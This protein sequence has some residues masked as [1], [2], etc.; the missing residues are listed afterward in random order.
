[1]RLIIRN[2]IRI[3]QRFKLAMTL[4]I[5]GLSIAFTA[6]MIIMMQW[7]Y[8]ITF[9]AETPNADCIYRVDGKNVFGLE[10]MP[11]CSQPMADVFTQSSPHIQ[12]GGL[13]LPWPFPSY[14][15]IDTHRGEKYTFKEEITLCTPT[16][17]DVFQFDMIE[18]SAD[19]LNAFEQILI[20]QSLAKKLFGNESAIGKRLETN[21]NQIFGS[22]GIYQVGGVFKDFPENSVIEN[23][24]FISMGDYGKDDWGTSNGSLYVRL[25]APSS[26]G[27]LLDNFYRYAEQI[28]LEGRMQESMD[29]GVYEMELVPLRELHFL[30]NSTFDFVPKADRFTLYLLF[31][32]AWVILI[33]AAINFTNFNTALSPVRMKSINTQ[34]ILGSTVGELR[35]NLTIETVLVSFGAYLLSIYLLYI[36]EYCNID[37]LITAEISIEHHLGLIALTGA[38]SVLLGLVAGLYPAYYMT[39]FQPALVLKG[40][41]GLSLSG[42]RL[43]TVLMSIQYATAFALIIAALFMSLQN[44]YIQ[45]FSLGY[46]KE[47]ILVAE[48]GPNAQQT[49]QAVRSEVLGISGVQSLTFSFD[50]ISARD[51]YSSWGR[52]FKDKTIRYYNLWCDYSFPE[53]MNIPLVEGRYFLPSDTSQNGS[54]IINKLMADMYGIT[55]GDK[56]SGM[57]VVGV[58]QDIK[59]MTLRQ[60]IEPMAFT[61]GNYDFYG[62]QYLYVRTAPKTDFFALRTELQKILDGFDNNLDTNIRFFD[63]VLESAYQSEWNLTTLITLFSFLAVF[64]SIVG[65]FGMVVFDSAYKRKEI[66][67][68]KVMG[69]TTAQILLLFNKNY[70]KMLTLCFVIAA[71]CAGYGIKVWLQNFAYKIPIYWWVFPLSFIAIAIVTVA[72]VTYQ[73]WHAANENPVNSIR[74]E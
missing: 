23:K 9:D 22:D 34:R 61:V 16:I 68:R 63:T 56:I 38:I 40:S 57:N 60:S 21:L 47:N 43:R 13:M 69:S 45:N 73:N 44:R 25:D 42:R 20:P 11:L 58:M 52:S 70:I 17:V 24:P 19:V 4:N 26:A 8:D 50:L 33:I 31:S 46:D 53:V 64:I 39:S 18:G 2:F 5:L 54:M 15:T 6:F 48:L 3:F 72:T 27:G 12:A 59:F 41:F 29:G 32:I 37:R 35:R 62:R 7:R 14:L 74:S 67:I 28:G 10:R 51:I 36:A 30:P 49:Y 65:V 71:P 66:G 55:V 1:M